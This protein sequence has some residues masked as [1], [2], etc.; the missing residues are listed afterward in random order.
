MFHAAGDARECPVRH[1]VRGGAGWGF[2]PLCQQPGDAFRYRYAR[3]PP[4]RVGITVGLDAGS[5][6]RPGVRVFGSGMRFGPWFEESLRVGGWAAA[7]C[8]HLS[9]RRTDKKS[10]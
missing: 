8:E 10:P 9:E 5:R 2:I 1:Q 6:K 7:A 4:R 3:S